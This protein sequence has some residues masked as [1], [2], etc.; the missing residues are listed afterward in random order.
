MLLRI[1]L[2]L[3]LAFALGMFA[4]SLVVTTTLQENA[5]RE[6]LGQA[7]LMLDSA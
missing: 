2:I 4:T 3:L 5:T 7:G 6:V 1:N